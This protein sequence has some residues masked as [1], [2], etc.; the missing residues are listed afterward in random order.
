MKTNI[1]T[2]TRLIQPEFIGKIDLFDTES[3]LEVRGHLAARHRM[4]K[5]GEPIGEPIGYDADSWYV[6]IG[7]KFPLVVS[8]QYR[9]SELNGDH[10][11]D[12]LTITQNTRE[13]EVLFVAL[14]K[15]FGIHGVEA[16]KKWAKVVILI[17]TMKSKANQPVED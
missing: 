17:Q 2:S 8:D 3:Y 14:L 7:L 12:L 1:A 6:R 16:S 5:R 15:A 13:A 10:G 9:Y 11:P 4:S